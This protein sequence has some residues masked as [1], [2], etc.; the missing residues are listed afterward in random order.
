MANLRNSTGAPA[1]AR[2][3]EP[4]QEVRDRWAGEITVPQPWGP[5]APMGPGNPW[6]GSAP[7]GPGRPGMGRTAEAQPDPEPEPLWTVEGGLDMS[8][9]GQPPQTEGL[10]MNHLLPDEV[11]ESP[12]TVNEAYL[13]SLKSMLNQ[14]KGNYIVATFLVG[15]QSTVTWEGILYEVGNDYVTIYQPGRDR[16][17]VSDMYSLRYLEFYDIERRELCSRLMREQGLGNPAW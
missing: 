1:P 4:A 17:I 15:T 2:P 16:Y 10:E 3:G 13:G 14:N 11:V 9:T 5:P 6:N 7:A 8:R 12:T